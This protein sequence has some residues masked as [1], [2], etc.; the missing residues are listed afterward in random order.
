MVGVKLDPTLG[1]NV[2]DVTLT[3]LLPQAVRTLSFP[4]S[5]YT[6]SAGIVNATDSMSVNAYQGNNQVHVYSTAGAGSTYVNTGAGTG[7]AGNNQITVGDATSATGLN[8]IQGPLFI[9][10]GNGANNSLT[11]TEAG[12]DFGDTLTLTN[13]ALIRYLSMQLSP[14]RG[15]DKQQRYAFQIAYQAT[16]GAFGGG[17]ELDTTQGPDTVYVPYTLANTHVTINTGNNNVLMSKK[18][19]PDQVFIG[20]DAGNPTGPPNPVSAASL[21]QILAPVTVIGQGTSGT[22]ATKLFIEDQGARSRKRTPCSGSPCPALK[23]SSAPE[24]PPFPIMGRT[25]P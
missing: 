18:P 15:A 13:D 19:A 2:E 7:Q 3:T 10:A 20:Y 12:S 4:S 14:Q 1:P 21:D 9:D 8:D 24:H 25:L 22:P 11:F 5:T 17:I 6:V 23:R 16:G